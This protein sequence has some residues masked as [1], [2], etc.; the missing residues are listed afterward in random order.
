[1]DINNIQYKDVI[2]PNTHFFVYKNKKYPFKFDYFKY[3]SK[4]FSENQKE[5][6]ETK[7]IQ[8][9]DDHENDTSITE[10]VIN[11]FIKFIQSEKIQ[12]D[13]ENVIGLNY[14][15]QKYE[16]KIL[17]KYGKN[18]SVL[19]DNISF[20]KLSRQ[21][22][23]L[24]INEYSTKINF[25][26]I[27]SNLIFAIKEYENELQ[28]NNKKLS[29]TISN[30]EKEIDQLKQ[31]ISNIEEQNN[32][33]NKKIDLNQQQYF[34]NIES[35]KQ[36]EAKMNEKYEKLI[37]IKES[38]IVKIKE[39][40]ANLSNHN[41]NLLNDI[42]LSQLKFWKE[43]DSKDQII[44]K[45]DTEITKIKPKNSSLIEKNSQ[46]EKEKQDLQIKIKSQ[47]DQHLNEINEMTNK[48]KKRINEQ[49]QYKIIS[50]PHDKGDFNGIFKYLNEQA[51]GN[52]RTN[53]IIEITSNSI[54]DSTSYDPYNLFDFK[55]ADDYAAKQGDF[56]PWVCF[57]FK[58]MKAKIISYTIKSSDYS[59]GHLKSWILEVSNDNNKWIT[60]A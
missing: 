33:L 27:T 5:L 3:G 8:I 21:Y 48:L 1:M 58:E 43:L 7:T 30:K 14:L 55:S 36:N 31:Q 34:K 26:Y 11:K 15:S 52:I 4:Y 22:V 54:L 39:Q 51:K 32:A 53:K 47:Q 57:D 45:K 37:S 41:K 25:E 59:I 18:A 50:L 44:I 2:H 13:N 24:L 10:V 17:D 35:Q 49:D 28:L 40:N 56:Y 60:L 23:N 38:E 19:F 12:L 9:L 20:E 42:K 46:L 6:V 16:V 29:N